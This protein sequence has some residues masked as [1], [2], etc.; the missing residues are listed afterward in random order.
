MAANPSATSTMPLKRSSA[1]LVVLLTLLTGGIYLGIW[2][3]R[4][5]K[6][7]NALESESKIGAFGPVVLIVLGV[8]LL[9]VPTPPPGPRAVAVL[10]GIVSLVLAFRTREIMMD[11]QR[12]LVRAVVPQSAGLQDQ[13]DPSSI[14]TFFFHVWYLQ[15]KINELVE[16]SA[17][18]T[19]S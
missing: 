10:L 17:A 11:H 6:A 15:H 19:S 5:A 13:F 3:L 4:R 14:L 8:V 12:H 9:F 2:Y 16:T 1:V 7:L 18:W